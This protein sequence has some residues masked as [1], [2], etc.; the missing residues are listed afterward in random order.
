AR[1]KTRAEH[2]R[3]FSLVWLIPIVAAAIGAWLAYKAISE[4]GPEITISF[5]SAA[6]LAAG[7]TEIRHKNVRLGVV[8]HIE[9]SQDLSSV[10][11]TAQ[12]EKWVAAQLTTGTRFWVVLPRLGFSGISGLET[13]VSGSYIELDP[14][15]GKSARSFVGLEEPPVVRAGES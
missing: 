1:I 8:N 3:R 7:K 10:V 5:E 9:L 4:Q 11:V 13:L 14:G 12:M 6:G 2:G 15:A